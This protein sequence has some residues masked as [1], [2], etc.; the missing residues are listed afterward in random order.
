[1]ILYSHT[2]THPCIARAV[3]MYVNL[4]QILNICL[5]C[6]VRYLGMVRVDCALAVPV[7]E[8]FKEEY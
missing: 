6:G 2:Y 5:D 3:R 1:M 8:W 7:A 4:G